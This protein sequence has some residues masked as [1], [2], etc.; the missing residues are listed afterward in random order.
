MNIHIDEYA[1]Q[2]IAEREPGSLVAT[3]E[4]STIEESKKITLCT[5]DDICD[6]WFCDQDISQP[7]VLL[8]PK[9]ILIQKMLTQQ[10]I[11]C[12]TLSV[13]ITLPDNFSEFEIPVNIFYTNS[14]C[15]LVIRIAGAFGLRGPQ[16]SAVQ[17]VDGLPVSRAHYGRWLGWVHLAPLRLNSYC[18]I[19]VFFFFFTW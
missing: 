15:F 8:Q 6:M 7:L 9:R 16:S 18:S 1:V 12:Q 3:H 2:V 19:I 14:V 11:S 5:F 4:P 13:Y 17:A 10:H